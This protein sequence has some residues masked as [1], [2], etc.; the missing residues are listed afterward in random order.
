[1][2]GSTLPVALVRPSENAFRIWGTTKELT[3]LKVQGLID[4]KRVYPELFALTP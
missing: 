1:M 4:F 3:P 2:P